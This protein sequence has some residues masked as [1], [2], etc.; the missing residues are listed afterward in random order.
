[1]IQAAIAALT[2]D[3]TLI[4][5]AH[6]VATITQVD[7]IA[8]LDQGRLVELGKHEQL[9]AANGLYARLW[10]RHQAAQN[11]GLNMKQSVRTNV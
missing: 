7:Q 8:V 9:I 4:V 1:L 6:R 10:S 11:W 2:Q 5:V 3:K